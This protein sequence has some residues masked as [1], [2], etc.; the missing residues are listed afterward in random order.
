M[1]LVSNDSWSMLSDHYSKK[2]AVK[3][4]FVLKKMEALEKHPEF[5][6]M[7]ADLKERGAEAAE[8]YMYNEYLMLKINKF[9]G[10]LPEEVAPTLRQAQATLHTA[11]KNGDL[12]AVQAHI[13]S[14][15]SIHQKDDKGIAALA[16]AIGA[17]R[18]PVVKCLVEGKAD[19]NTVDSEGN[20][21]L[22][23]AAA[24]GRT[25]LAE[26]LMTVGCDKLRTNN[27]GQIPLDLATKNKM[28]AVIAL[29]K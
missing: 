29:L 3:D 26:Y 18:T 16:Y 12:E 9:M 22:H 24:Y 21:G 28:T 25:D 10:G 4:N 1:A 6:D 23:Y 17:N 14:K 27:A 19:L 11:C 7:M 5:K 8:E 20:N 13:A 2:V 15:G